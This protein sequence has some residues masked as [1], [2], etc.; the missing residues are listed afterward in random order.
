MEDVE[1]NLINRFR[2]HAH[3]FLKRE[4]TRWET[5]TLAQHYGL[6]TRLLDWTYNPLAALYFAAESNANEDG[7]VF[8]FRPVNKLSDY[9]GVYPDNLLIKKHVPEPLKVEGIK[10]IFPMMSSDRLVAQCGGFT[11]QV[12]WKP[13]E[14]QAGESFRRGTLDIVEMF[15]WRVPKASK[16]EILGQLNRLGV[17]HRALFPDLG[18]AAVGLL[19]SQLLRK[20]DI[21]R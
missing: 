10:I 2:R 13:L 7:A 8:A 4:P 20:D 12:P 15:K 14:A 17:H 16:V 9:I 5:I 21:T 6:P 1:Y 19:R 18:G 3:S 11:I